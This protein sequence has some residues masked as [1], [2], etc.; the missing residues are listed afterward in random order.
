M[1]VFEKRIKS[2]L[3]VLTSELNFNS[4]QRMTSAFFD[5]P[6][7]YIYTSS[8]YLSNKHTSLNLIS[9]AGIS[10]TSPQLALLKCVSELCERYALYTLNL[11]KIYYEEYQNMNN[12]INLH[13]YLPTNRLKNIKF[14]WVQAN[15]LHDDA[16]HYVPFQLIYFNKIKGHTEPLLCDRNSTGAAGGFNKFE[17]IL[18]G[19][20]EV[21]ERDS[22]MVAYLG[23]K[24][25]P[26]VDVK[27]IR[28]TDIQYIYDTYCR[29]N[30]EV[31]LVNLTNDLGI[32][33]YLTVLIDKA[34]QVP[35]FT[36]GAKSNLNPLTAI[37]GSLEEAFM[38]R[39]W[40]RSLAIKGKLKPFIQQDT[41]KIKSHIQRA[42]Y[43][44]TRDNL[45]RLS[46]LIN[47][48]ESKF[49]NEKVNLFSLKTE[50]KTLRETLLK[51]GINIYYVNI[52]PDIFN[53]TNYMVY[54]VIAP[55]LQPL[56][57]NEANKKIYYERVKSSNINSIPHPFL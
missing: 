53:K 21:I 54:K 36:L 26:T 57:L 9:S 8:V 3:K 25:Y 17:T 44:T 2:L 49:D 14:A 28:N 18:R 19:I 11:H 41:K 13:N 15:S 6:P 20:Y 4:L 31:K 32:P 29:Y 5:E 27:T 38:S 55:Q 22:F 30:Y 47:Q 56:Y 42:S 51:K 12:Q 37:L 40:L 45:H 33:T 7:F 50:F 39:E 1:S 23:K 48:K 43:W 35:Y 52:T 34:K 24:K 10:A 16:T 46:F